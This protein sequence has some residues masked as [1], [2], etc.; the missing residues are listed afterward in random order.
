MCTRKPP[1]YLDIW[2]LFC[3][4]PTRRSANVARKSNFSS[5]FVY[6]THKTHPKQ[7]EFCLWLRLVNIAQLGGFKLIYQVSW[8]R[9][10]VSAK[11]SGPSS[12]QLDYGYSIWSSNVFFMRCLAVDKWK[13][14]ERR[15]AN[16]STVS[17]RCAM[18][19]WSFCYKSSSAM[20]SRWTRM[21]FYI[22]G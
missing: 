3:A 2:Y 8:Q 5:N 16:R 9:K 6:K 7:I 21:F 15:K 11:F 13:L 19:A 18:I 4:L 17:D 12:Q 20:L 22:H 1:S 14:Q 10:N